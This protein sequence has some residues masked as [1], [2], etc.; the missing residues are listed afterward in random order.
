M[1]LR[2]IKLSLSPYCYIYLHIFFAYKFII[3]TYFWMFSCIFLHT[4]ISAFTFVFL[5]RDNIVV[6]HISSDPFL[7]ALFLVIAV[8]FQQALQQQIRVNSSLP[9]NFLYDCC[10]QAAA[11]KLLACL[12]PHQTAAG[13][14]QQD[15]PPAQSQPHFK[16]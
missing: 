12:H 2:L 3:N 7:L 4:N 6:I 11:W 15:W 9:E 5:A 14:R 16:C 8:S 10:R 1:I 13:H